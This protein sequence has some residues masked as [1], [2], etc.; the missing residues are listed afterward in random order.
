MTQTFP[1]SSGNKSFIFIVLVMTIVLLIGCASAPQVNHSQS[2]VT[3]PADVQAFID[4]FVKDMRMHDMAKISTH[5]SDNFKLDGRNRDQRLSFLSGP[6]ASGFFDKYEYKL[7]KFDVDKNNPNI[8]HH[9]G[10]VNIGFADRTFTGHM[11]IKE[12]GK[13]KFYGNQ[14]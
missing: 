11:L 14:K 3:V 2:T 7:T 4:Q 12:D 8:V 10:Y 13:W 6:A 9:D 1:V 5:F